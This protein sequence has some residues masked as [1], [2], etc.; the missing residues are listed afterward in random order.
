MVAHVVKNFLTS[1]GVLSTMYFQ[2]SVHPDPIY[3]NQKW[4]QRV[5]S[6]RLYHPTALH[7]VQNQKATILRNPLRSSLFWGVKHR[8]LIG[9]SQCFGTPYRLYLQQPSSPR[10][11]LSFC[12]T[13]SSIITLTNE[14]YPILKCNY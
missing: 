4:K 3:S 1:V 13:L 7:G 10:N 8:R 5:P 2:V 9:S 12:S 11:P 14:Y 6:E